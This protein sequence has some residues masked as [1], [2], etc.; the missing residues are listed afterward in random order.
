MSQ[1]SSI[2]QS[3][4]AGPGSTATSLIHRAQHSDGEAWERLA[5]LYG[6][7]I[8]GWARR[9]GMQEHDAA[10]VMQAVF[11]ALTSDLV[12]F[13][14]RS[15]A[16]SFRGWLWTITRNKVMDE[17][18][19]LYRREDAIGGSNAFQKL[20]EM[21]ESPP[22]SSSD[23]SRIEQEALRRRALEMVSGDFESR[24]WQAFF[25]TA[26]KGDLPADVAADLGISVWAVYKA[27]SRVLQKFRAE[28]AD[29]LD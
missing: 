29:V 21:P 22:D 5:H 3:R 11:E 6:P 18:R 24:T 1:L 14:R 2:S 7:T 8:Y 27:R 9:A 13:R 25:R 20:Q 23:D 19:R 15:K 16:D 10:D 12:N 26:V 17:F 4:G 28:F